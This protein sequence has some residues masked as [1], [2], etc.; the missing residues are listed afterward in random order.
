[1]KHLA[2]AALFLSMTAGADEKAP[3][4]DPNI[5]KTVDALAGSWVMSGVF[6]LPDGK[7]VDV[8]GETFDCKRVAGGTAV[9]C[10]D[11]LN[12]P[13]MGISDGIA[14]IAWDGEI[15]K[16]HVVG[17]DSLGLFHDHTCV[18]KDDKTLTCDPLES[19]VGGNAATVD[20]TA[21]F[22]DAKN[23]SMTETFTMKDGSK[24]GYDGKGKRK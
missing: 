22:S 14:L 1:M 20:F 21:T 5:K 19:S 24:W 2:L 10:T 23:V 6:T 7:K 13:G 18:W 12:I 16:V 15:K 8:K 17:A 4:P 3:P 9:S 11:K